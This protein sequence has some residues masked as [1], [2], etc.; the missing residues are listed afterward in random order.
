MLET[1]SPD[2]APAMHPYQRNSPEFLPDICVA[3]AEVKGV[4]AEELAAASTRNAMEL[5]GWK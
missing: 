1:D 5:F 2:M 4:S 3:V